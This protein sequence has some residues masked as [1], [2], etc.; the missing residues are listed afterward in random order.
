MLHLHWRRRDFLVR[1]SGFADT[2][3]IMTADTALDA[4]E[5]KFSQAL[6]AATK[7]PGVRINRDSYLRSALRRYCTDEQIALAIAESP[8]AA[9]VSPEAIADIANSSIKL[10]TSRVTGASTL[11]GIPGGFAMLGTVPADLAQYLG[12]MLRITQKLAYIYSWPDLFED[13]GDEVDDATV[14]MLTLFVGVMFGVN[15]AQSGVATVSQSI[16]TQLARQLP[17]QALTHG[18]LYP[19]VKKVATK[20]GIR[21]TTGIFAKGVSK[22]VP[23]V[24][25]VVSGGL[26]LATFLP[27]ARKLQKHLAS[28]EL[29]KPGLRVESGVANLDPDAGGRVSTDGPRPPAGP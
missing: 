4:S 20:L 2:I 1:S 3:R 17:R 28:L 12:H 14:G 7:L 10:E 24:G 11:A 16:A 26:T 25:A 23:I 21:M 18:T 6:E 8:A 13:D 19:I 27:M 29:T 22:A 5:S 9:D 15:I